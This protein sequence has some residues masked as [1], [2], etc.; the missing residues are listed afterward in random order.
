MSRHT[1]KLLF[2]VTVGASAGLPASSV[3][4]ADNSVRV[5]LVRTAA[6]PHRIVHV[7]DIAEVSGG[8][9]AIR[10]KIAELDVT[11]LLTPRSVE[12]I[13]KEQIALRVR[14]SGV[15]HPEFT[16]TGAERVH[17]SLREEREISDQMVLDMLRPKLAAA[18]HVGSDDVE[19]RLTRPLPTSLVSSGWDDATLKPFLP[20]A[21]R[22]GQLN[23]KVGVYRKQRLVQSVGVAVDLRLLRDV[24]VADRRLAPGEQITHDNV[25]RERRPLTGTASSDFAEDAIGKTLRRGLREGDLLLR[26][27][28]T[29]K[30]TQ[31]QV[32]IRSR[33]VV[34]LVARK[35]N[36]HVSLQGAQALQAGA[37]GEV[38]RVRNPQSGKVITGRVVDGSTVEI[39]L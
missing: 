17:V 20:P 29:T 18:L 9:P 5:A 11:E 7:G 26:S 19:L 13:S 31:R 6:V 4:A 24:F 38:I 16:V 30:T 2:F 3:P 27:N 10:R 22:P 39:R 34:S 32:A 8:N 33:D 28:L 36:L 25:R 1:G 14:L 23:L 15:R 12:K 35:G 37:I 21:L